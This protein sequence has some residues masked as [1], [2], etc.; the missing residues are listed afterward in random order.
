MKFLRILEVR[1]RQ[2]FFLDF[3]RLKT[4]DI[5]E[6]ISR[7]CHSM[8]SDFCKA[9]NEYN[10]YICNSI[11]TREKEVDKLHFLVLRQ[12][13]VASDYSDIAELLEV[14][15]KIMEYR[16]VV[17]A[18]ERVADHA[19]NI[20]ESLLNLKKPVSELCSL[21]ELS[22]EMLQTSVVSFF[23]PDSEFAEEVLERYDSVLKE[24][25]KYYGFILNR[26]LEEALL[27]KTIIDSLFRIIGYSSDIA[28]VA[29]NLSAQ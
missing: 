11:I 17:R 19:A 9:F 13:K 28:E 29:I 25:Q 3:K 1:Y 26:T 20:A 23:K 27:V 16:T 12:L 14:S 22:A 24:E 18:L 21:A 5:V 8:F 4:T 7:I 2:R 6:K 10:E 15:G